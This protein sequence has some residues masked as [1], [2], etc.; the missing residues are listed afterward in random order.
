MKNI[1]KLTSILLIAVMLFCSCTTTI[2]TQISTTEEGTSVPT[3]EPTLTE[4][5]TP[6]PTSVED[7][8]RIVYAP[9]CYYRP[10]SSNSANKGRWYT[11]GFDKNDLPSLN[12]ELKLI[13]ET[14]DDSLPKNITWNYLGVD[15]ELQYEY[16]GFFRYN[17]MTDDYTDSYST[18]P[19]YLNPTFKVVFLHGTKK[20]IYI[21]CAI[22]ECK[23]LMSHINY[24]N[25]EEDYVNVI[26]LNNQA[27]SKDFTDH[28]L[29]FVITYD[30]Y[31]GEKVTYTNLDDVKN[32]GRN[33]FRVEAFYRPKEI[34][35][36]SVQTSPD[37]WM[38]K[39][40]WIICYAETDFSEYTKPI[41]ISQSTLSYACDEALKF[42]E[43]NFKYSNIDGQ[44]VDFEL[45]SPTFKSSE[46]TLEVLNGRLYLL[47][48]IHLFGE[49][50][51]NDQGEFD[52]VFQFYVDYERLQQKMALEGK[53]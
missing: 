10:I 36:F 13:A 1:Y 45:A 32:T 5:K 20:P 24:N 29:E 34:S 8:G 44:S 38:N 52:R 51:S 35:G 31:D 16:S 14:I 3:L 4:N 27:F 49:W 22:D 46:T 33:I 25:L 37:F 18:D 9:G 28:E 6:M 7:I 39:K 26:K 21:Q 23:D 41:K 30:E 47:L 53:S 40:M 15:I 2:D 17:S 48:D 42:A 43:E 50:G 19:G 12:E 11:D